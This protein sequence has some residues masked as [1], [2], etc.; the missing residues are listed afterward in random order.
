MAQFQAID[1]S[2]VDI[3]LPQGVWREGASWSLLRHGKL[4]VEEAQNLQVGNQHVSD[5]LCKLLRPIFIHELLCKLAKELSAVVH[6][7]IQLLELII[8]ELFVLQLIMDLQSEG[9]YHGVIVL[10]P[11]HVH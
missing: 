7:F 1:V 9:R 4:A 8:T 11:R 10:T 6:R 2:W 3:L 5:F